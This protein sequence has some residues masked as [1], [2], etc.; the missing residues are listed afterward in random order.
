MAQTRLDLVTVTVSYSILRSVKLASHNYL[1]LVMGADSSGKP[2]IAL[3][4]KQSSVVSVDRD[5]IVPRSHTTNEGQQMLIALYE[6]LMV[7][8]VISNLSMGDTLVV[9]DIT[10]SMETALTRRYREKGLSLLILSTTNSTSANHVVDLYENESKRSIRSKLPKT[11][12]HFVNLSTAKIIAKEITACLPAHCNVV[13]TESLTDNR[14]FITN[15]GFV[16]LDSVIPNLL[17]T[18]CAHVK[19]ERYSTELYKIV[20]ATPANISPE[21]AICKALFLVDWASVLE[22]P[23]CIQPASSMV[24]FSDDKT[25]WLV[26]LTGGRGLL[27]CRWMV[28]RGARYVVMTSR[29]PKVDISWLEEIEALGAIVKVFSN[30]I[31]NR[32][33]VQ[34]AYKTLCK[35]M[36]PIGGV[37]QGAMVLQD[38]MFADMDIETVERVMIPK[39]NGS[40]YLDEIFHDSPLEFFIF[41]SS[42][43]A[44]SGNKGQSIYGAANTFMHALAAQRRQRGVAGSVVDIG[45]VMGNGY[46]IRELTEQQ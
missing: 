8:G 12:S 36:P 39:V 32:N 38:M 7:Q 27:I 40:I 2:V 6:Q 13:I 1:F 15:T 34:S 5:W 37:A 3:S 26:G 24:R 19:A 45:C 31:T 14:L 30:D 16:G 4:D 20:S 21:Q 23:V 42:V 25:Y 44:I 35:T 22:L 33:A 17:K 11:I 28:D 29:N 43:A 46:V 18:A 10:E 9:L 41:F